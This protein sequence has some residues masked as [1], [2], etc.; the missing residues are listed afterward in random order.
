MDTA[1]IVDVVGD[2][3]NLKKAGS[4]Y[5]GLC[6]FHNEKTP[7]FVVNPNKNIFKCFGCGQG[8]DSLKFVME[9]EKLSY[10][11]ALRYL[12]QKYNIEV[13]ETHT[14]AEAQ[15]EKLETESLLIVLNYAAKFYQQQLFE[16]EAGK[17][18][19]LS[20]FKERGFREDTIR[21]FMLGY[22]PDSYDAFYKQAKA[23]GHSEEILAKAGLIKEKNGK[24]YDFFRDRVMFP[25]F[26][27]TG[28][29][30]AF[31]GRTLK[32]GENQPKYI[33]TPETDVYHKSRVL[34]GIFQAKNEIRAKDVCFLVEGYTDV[35]SLHQAGIR[36]VVA[37]SGTAL[38]KDQVLLIKRFTENIVI[39]Y[40]GDPAGVKAALRGLDIVLEQ[41][42]NVRLV[43]LP[44][45]EDPDSFVQKNGADAT[46]DFVEKNKKDF[47]LF[48]ASLGMKE[49]GSDPIRKSDVIK[50]I[51]E[52]IA[53]IGDPIKRQLYIKECA[54][55]VDIPEHILV[56][57]TNK[58][59][60][61]ILR[62]SK[63]LSTE[64]GQVVNEA[65]KEEFD[66]TQRVSQVPRLYYQEKDVVRILLE[67][68]DKEMQ[69]GENVCAYVLSELVDVPFKHSVFDKIVKLYLDAYEQ[70]IPFE[71]V[72]NIQLSGDEDVK[73]TL[74]EML[75]PAHELSPNWY[76]R[77][78]IVVR[79]ANRTYKTDVVS[80]MSRFRYYKIMEAVKILDEKI[81]DAENRQ[82]L[83]ELVAVIL[84]KQELL[85]V[86]KNLAKSIETVIHP[87]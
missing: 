81:K 5:K 4:V 66:H 33:N 54:E 51:V 11:E 78:E 41:G 13:E 83:E 30:I 12:A 43:L 16:S 25:I 26:N 80:V 7:S 18:I 2:F 50:D 32:S 76:G 63:E 45:G 42:L 22:S 35:I 48:K 24:H 58:I 56:N 57:E 44:D 40:D 72:R 84:K 61:Q 62:K 53:L 70:D 19:G 8:G 31:G 69:E 79:D 49:V 10:P 87:H 52:S 55:I 74:I 1:H 75:T 36:N 73:Q 82:E 65:V 6:P 38:T 39:L 9:H 21:S 15:Q 3:V 14:S 27:V 47:I 29:P 64:E 67:F 59:R 86:R 28:K 46:I 68:A 85:E 77:H 60:T 17:A 23:E 71:Q 20:Y 34:Y 37:S